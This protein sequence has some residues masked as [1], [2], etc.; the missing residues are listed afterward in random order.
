MSVALVIAAVLSTSAAPFGPPQESGAMQLVRDA[1]VETNFQ[2]SALERLGRERRWRPQRMTQRSGEPGQVTAF[3]A[4]N[5]LIMLMDGPSGDGLPRLPGQMCS[6]SFDRAAPELVGE[7]AG[8]AASLGLEDE[9]A[10]DGFPGSVPV[11]VWSR[12]GDKTLTYAAA[13]GRAVVSISRQIVT[14]EP[15]PVSPS[16]N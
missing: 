13:D 3:R 2:R 7:V 16:G 10:A 15:A 11:R 4:D 9:G 6:V 14:H 5:V 12:L 8:L 1:C